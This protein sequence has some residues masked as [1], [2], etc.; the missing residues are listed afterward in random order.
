MRHEIEFFYRPEK[1]VSLSS[2]TTHVLDEDF[3]ARC[4]EQDKEFIEHFW[5][6]EVLPKNKGATSAPRGRANLVSTI[7]NSDNYSRHLPRIPMMNNSKTGAITEGIIH[8]HKGNEL[9]FEYVEYKY[10]LAASRTGGQEPRPLRAELYDSMRIAAVGAALILP[11]DLVL[12]HRRAYTAT[13]VAGVFDCS[14]AGVLPVDACGVY[15]ERGLHEKLK[16]ELGLEPDEVAIEGITGVHSAGSP[17]FSGLIT[18]ILRTPLNRE[19]IKRRIKPGTF[20]EVRYVPR[21][22]LSDFVIE[23]YTAQD[24]NHDG[25]MTLLSSLDIGDWYDSI[26]RLQAAGK[27]IAFGSL[28]RGKFCPND[29]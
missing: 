18:T 16:K 6:T 29:S 28:V 25:A 2:L 19:E 12:V 8:N 3:S 9:T 21:A 5:A 22:E 4:T 23:R 17:D 10:Y 15:L 14:T 24:M 1:P 13:H 27:D 20:P 7:V 11:D 26:E